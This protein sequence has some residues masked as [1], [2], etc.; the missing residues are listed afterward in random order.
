MRQLKLIASN[1]DGAALIIVMLVLVAVTAVGITA[2]NIS[3]TEINLAGNDKWQKTGFYNGDA[4]LFGTPLIISPNFNDDDFRTPLQPADPNDPNDQGCLQYINS[5][6]PADFKKLVYEIHTEAD[7]NLPANK[8][9]SFRACDIDAD[10]DI[11]PMRP[12]AIQGGGVEFASKGSEGTGA[13]GS[14]GKPFGLTSTGDGASS[15]STYTIFGT[16]L[17]VD[18]GGGLR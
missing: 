17:F 15:N 10:I 6:T 7:P 2:N 1:Q 13:S 18:Q 8:D 12:I 3:T 16:Y 11:F 9:I 14:Q 4:G 5:M